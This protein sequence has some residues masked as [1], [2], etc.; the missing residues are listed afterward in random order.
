MGLLASI[1]KRDKKISVDRATEFMMLLIAVLREN[2]V[3]CGVEAETFDKAFEMT[4]QHFDE[5]FGS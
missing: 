2:I 1:L 5:Y 4:K 3:Q